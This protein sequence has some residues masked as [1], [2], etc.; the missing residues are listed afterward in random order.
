MRELWVRIED[1]SAQEVRHSILRAASEACSTIIVE[2]VDLH[3]ARAF[4]LRTVMV[5]NGD[6]LLVEEN[7]WGRIDQLRVQ[8]KPLC[9]SISVRSRV[10][11]EKALKAAEIGFDFIL[12]RCP[13]WKI[14]PFE[15]LIAKTRGRVKLIAEVFSPN[16]ARVALETLEIGVDG[17]ALVTSCPGY[18]EETKKILRNIEAQGKRLELAQTKVV[19]VS[20]LSLGHRVC[21]DTCDI[22]APGEGLLIGCQSSG[23]FLIQA[24]VQE[25]PHVEPRPF[26]VNAGPI[27]LYVLTPGNRTRYLSEL[28]AGDEVNVVDRIGRIRSVVVGRVKIERRPL[29]LVET[30][31]EGWRIKTIVQNAETIRFVTKDGSKAVTELKGGDEV[32]VYHQTGGRHF[33]TLVSEESVIER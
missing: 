26:R 30:E 15:N 28:R 5:E 23:L 8:G 11:E 2:E 29:A 33:G 19:E 22:M 10:D 4:G 27:S 1:S 25:N 24:E 16:E 7:D 32:L 20:Q 6:I 3:N 18:V 17:V 13:D 12:I 14:I 31:V 21:I 9:A